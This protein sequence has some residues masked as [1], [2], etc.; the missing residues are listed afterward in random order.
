M[1]EAIIFL[2]VRGTWVI[3][4][5]LIGSERFITKE[6]VVKESYLG[7]ELWERCRRWKR[8]KNVKWILAFHWNEASDICWTLNTTFE[9]ERSAE[10]YRPEGSF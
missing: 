6:F 10:I 7:R 2:C 9:A 3:S 1:I 5:K 4:D 8:I